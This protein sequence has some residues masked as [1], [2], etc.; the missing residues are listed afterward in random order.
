MDSYTINEGT[1]RNT[2]FQSVEETLGESIKISAI[3]EFM[4]K[5]GSNLVPHEDPI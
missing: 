3:A 4:V 1:L 2:W 5:W